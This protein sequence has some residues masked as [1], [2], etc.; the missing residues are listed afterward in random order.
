MIWH[1]L[2]PLAVQNYPLFTQ[3]LLMNAQGCNATAMLPTLLQIA[4]GQCTTSPKI[5]RP[6]GL[7]EHQHLN[8]LEKIST[9]VQAA[10]TPV[11]L[12]KVKSH[13]NILGNEF[14]DTAAVAVANGEVEEP[15]K[16]DT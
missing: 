5:V 6:Q 12:W 3:P 16:Y 10:P 8:I 7:R 2:T 14:A 1:A 15:Y 11:H 4:W 13:T 9:L